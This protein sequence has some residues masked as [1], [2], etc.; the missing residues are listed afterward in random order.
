MGAIANEAGI[1]SR[2]IGAIDIADRFT[3]VEVDSP[4]AQAVVTA[5]RG[6]TIK[7][8]TV[9]VRRDQPKRAAGYREPRQ[10]EGGRPAKRDFKNKTPKRD[11]FGD[12]GDGAKKRAKKSRFEEE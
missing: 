7:G 11:R 10:D 1:A 6:T 9:T 3:L 5:L 2:R 4:V 12:L 8:R